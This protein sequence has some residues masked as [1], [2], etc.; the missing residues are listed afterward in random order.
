MQK[1]ED[2]MNLSFI[3]YHVRDLGYLTRSASESKSDIEYFYITLVIIK[4][5]FELS[6]WVC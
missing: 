4:Q 2:V 3:N 5:R 6:S 1:S